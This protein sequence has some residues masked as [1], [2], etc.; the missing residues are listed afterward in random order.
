MHYETRLFTLALFHHRSRRLTIS[1]HSDDLWEDTLV[2]PS[3]IQGARVGQRARRHL[4]QRLYVRTN[5][6]RIP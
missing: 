4:L 5:P 3:I 6:W 1:L 2:A